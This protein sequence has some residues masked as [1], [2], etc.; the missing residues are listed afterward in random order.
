MYIVQLVKFIFF[1]LEQN[2]LAQRSTLVL[3]W[4]IPGPVDPMPL[5]LHSKQDE[6]RKR[7]EQ[8]AFYSVC[9]IPLPANYLI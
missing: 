4:N 5:Q 3:M 2:Y 1:Q 9:I 6:T 8:P 7:K